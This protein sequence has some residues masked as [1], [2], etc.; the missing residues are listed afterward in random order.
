MKIFFIGDIVGKPG[1]KAVGLVAP[2]LKERE[3]IEF[4]IANGENSAGGFGITPSVAEEIF[5]FGVDSITLG[6]HTWDRKEVKD[7]L[8][9]PRIIRPANYP[10]DV[11]GHG[12]QIFT[13]PT[14]VKLAV[15]CVMGRVY[16]QNLDCPFR[17]LDSIINE[18][19]KETNKIVVDVHAE[20]TSEK[21]SIGWFLDG[22]VSAVVGTHT[23]VMTA[24]ERILPLGTAYITDC[25]IT[26]SLDSVIGVKKELVLKK[27]ILQ[28][29]V[30]FEV[31]E[32]NVV[33]QGVIIDI[34]EST[35]KAKSIKRYTEFLGNL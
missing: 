5:S 14:G 30:K 35:G 10:P 20:I 34:D 28:V 33:L 6:N 18:I 3:N 31:A 12:Y 19:H 25:G 11:P 29:P 24:D 27:F 17:V 4:V 13:T 26:G 8:G 9:D 21:Q 1:R 16:M 15:V 23:H 2:S 32:E 22:K 7:I